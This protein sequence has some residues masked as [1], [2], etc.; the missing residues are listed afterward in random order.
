MLVGG[1]R[2]R[3]LEGMRRRIYSPPPASQGLDQ[4]SAMVAKL[5]TQHQ[6]L[7]KRTTADQSH[8]SRLHQLLH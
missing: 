5:L 4:G 3:T 8:D 7:D 2:I 6:G 1:S